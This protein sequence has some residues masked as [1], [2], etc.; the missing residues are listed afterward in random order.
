MSLYDVAD[1]LTRRAMKE[2]PRD[3]DADTPHRSEDRDSGE[4]TFEPIDH[5]FDEVGGEG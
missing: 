3:E 1:N 4:V 5:E 2:S